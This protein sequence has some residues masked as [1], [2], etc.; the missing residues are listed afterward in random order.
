[1]D[2][3]ITEMTT[4]AE[5]ISNLLHG[6][7]S[8]LDPDE[9]LTLIEGTSGK[10]YEIGTLLVDDCKKERLAFNFLSV[11]KLVT[12]ARKRLAET[13]RNKGR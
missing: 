5:D 10:L 9:L 3:R 6:E 1:M 7:F 11:R 4:L 13:N 8:H 12:E 2:A